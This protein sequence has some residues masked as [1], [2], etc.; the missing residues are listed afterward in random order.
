MIIHK[1]LGKSLG[2]I[3][4]QG[5]ASKKINNDVTPIKWTKMIYL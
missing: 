4:F 3:M 1:Q 2:W 5:I